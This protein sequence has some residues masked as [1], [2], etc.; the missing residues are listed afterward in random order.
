MNDTGS[1]KEEWKQRKK[2]IYYYYM[3]NK[4]DLSVVRKLMSDQNFNASLIFLPLLFTNRS[5]NYQSVRLCTN[6]GSRAGAGKSTENPKAM[7]QLVAEEDLFQRHI[8]VIG[9][10]SC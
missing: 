4:L 2:E 1:N 9:L 5:A 3:L 7:Q 8:A 10:S 6:E